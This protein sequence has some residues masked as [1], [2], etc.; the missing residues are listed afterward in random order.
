M[1]PR[2]TCFTLAALSVTA[3]SS[4]AAVG[5]DSFVFEDM[6]TSGGSPFVRSFD[7]TATGSDVFLVVG[8]SGESTFQETAVTWDAAGANQS[9]TEAIR[10]ESEA[11]AI[12][13][14]SIWVLNSPALGTLD[15][16]IDFTGNDFGNSTG[17]GIWQV[18]GTDGNMPQVA[19]NGVS[20][21]SGTVSYSGLIAGS[22]GIQVANVNNNDV[23][24]GFAATSGSTTD[25]ALDVV[26]GSSTA[27]YGDT[28]NLG[29]GDQDLTI[30]LNANER[31]AQS[32]A[33]FSPVPEPSTYAL[34]AGALALGFV[35][36]RRRR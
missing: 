4:H 19:G 25:R 6:D 13:H 12:T 3:I 21:A 8:F 2:S 5:V 16:T 17:L 36:L 28:V 7:V 10:T 15:L 27:G 11:N 34:M 20:G 14:S 23:I 26:S 29:A 32:T 24:D 18:S 35:A 22:A 1:N 9:L 31:I 30:N 33:V